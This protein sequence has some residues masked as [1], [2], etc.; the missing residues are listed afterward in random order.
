MIVMVERVAAIFVVVTGKWLYKNAPNRAPIWLEQTKTPN[1]VDLQKMENTLFESISNSAVKRERISYALTALKWCRF[2]R[3]KRWVLLLRL[4]WIPVHT[5]RSKW[6]SHPCSRTP[7]W[8]TESSKWC[9]NK[10]RRWLDQV[11]ELLRRP[12]K[13]PKCTEWD[14]PDSISTST[15]QTRCNQS[16]C[17]TIHSSGWFAYY[18]AHSR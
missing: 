6:R 1:A 17:R 5:H 2:P 3:W 14:H 10:M 13:W 9:S 8:R 11:V 18:S 4:K 12:T 15:M 16:P 7:K